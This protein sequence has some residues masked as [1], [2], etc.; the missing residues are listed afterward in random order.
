MDISDVLIRLET[1]WKSYSMHG[2]AIDSWSS[3]SIFKEEYDILIREINS[4]RNRMEI[5]EEREYFQRESD[6]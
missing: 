6:I 2:E 4:L 1:R 3:V 5:L